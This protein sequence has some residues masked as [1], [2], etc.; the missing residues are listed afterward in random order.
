M[1][2]QPG[3]EMDTNLPLRP[4]LAEAPSPLRLHATA[5]P[6]PGLPP[7]RGISTRL[8]SRSQ[9]PSRLPQKLKAA[10]FGAGDKLESAWQQHLGKET[11][12]VG[13]VQFIPRQT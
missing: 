3:G 6:R 8:P 7:H 11:S 10:G 4:A 9:F 13:Q 12:S 1:E 2:E 5:A